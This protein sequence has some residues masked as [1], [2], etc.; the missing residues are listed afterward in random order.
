MKSV[1]RESGRVPNNLHTD[2]GKEFYNKN[3]QALMTKYRINL[4]STYSNLK[5]SICERFNRTLKN[6]MWKKFSLRG[7]YKWL[8]I[9]PALLTAYNERKHRTT[10]MKPKDVTKS[11]EN[12][13]MHKFAAVQRKKKTKFQVG[14]KVRVSRA[15]QS[16]EKGYTPNW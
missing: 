13:V 7:N 14:D 5:A 16:F 15:K 8:D 4:Y 1:L 10:G 9:L 12:D 11:N 3:F 2:R 6:E